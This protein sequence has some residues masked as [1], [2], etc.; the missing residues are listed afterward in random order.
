MNSVKDNIYYYIDKLVKSTTDKYIQ[1]FVFEIKMDLIKYNTLDQ[2]E[3]YLLRKK[4]YISCNVIKLNVVNNIVDQIKLEKQKICKHSFSHLETNTCEYDL[5]HC[6]KKFIDNL[7]L[8]QNWIDAQTGWSMQCLMCEIKTSDL[9]IKLGFGI[10]KNSP[11][12]SDLYKLFEICE[13]NQW[14]C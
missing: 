8:K 6:P 4:N 12:D 7:E 14:T 1:L 11:D 2:F 5:S 3:L 13:K 9:G 10:E